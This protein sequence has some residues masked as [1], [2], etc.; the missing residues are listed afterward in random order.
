MRGSNRNSVNCLTAIEVARPIG[1][2][3]MRSKSATHSTLNKPGTGFAPA[4]SLWRP[5]PWVIVALIASVAI[6]ITVGEGKWPYTLVLVAAGCILM[7]PVQMSLGIFALTVPFDFLPLTGGRSGLTLTFLVGAGATG[8]LLV[9]GLVNRRLEM[10]SRSALWW[11]LFVTWATAT[12][13]WAVDPDDAI[14]RL[15]TAWALMLLYLVAVS[16]RVTKKQFVAIAVMAII[17][18]CIAAG[19]AAFSFYQGVAFGSTGRASLILGDASA[20]PNYFAASLLLPLSLAIGGLLSSRSWL[21]RLAFLASVLLISYA[22][23]LSMSRGALLALLLMAFVYL[24]RLQAKRAVL[25][26]C[27]HVRYRSAGNAR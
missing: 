24:R 16:F 7:W 5:S 2:T 23:L 4:W 9:E 26:F 25:V 21:K 8:I 10:P 27:P 12:V 17:G 13:A 3:T 6:G 11:L 14:H 15:P 22:L 19:Y 20:D 1:A 18:G